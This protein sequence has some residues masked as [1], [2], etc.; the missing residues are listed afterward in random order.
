M[1]M[2]LAE[3]IIL[4]AMLVVAGESRATEDY[5]TMGEDMI[6]REELSMTDCMVNMVAATTTMIVRMIAMVE[7]TSIEATIVVMEAMVADIVGKIGTNVQAHCHIDA[8]ATLIDLAKIDMPI[9]TATMTTTGDVLGTFQLVART[10][11]LPQIVI[12][13]MIVSIGRLSA[14]EPSRSLTSLPSPI[15]ITAGGPRSST[16]RRRLSSRR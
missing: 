5:A 13:E 14:I 12:M 3:V 6:V 10:V 8:T 7:G 11:A 9:E 4:I 2:M 15:K 16:L 1:A